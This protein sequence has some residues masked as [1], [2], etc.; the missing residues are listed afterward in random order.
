[1]IDREPAEFSITQACKCVRAVR[2]RSGKMDVIFFFPSNVG[3]VGIT[4]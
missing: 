1:M 2:V 3:T 4:V